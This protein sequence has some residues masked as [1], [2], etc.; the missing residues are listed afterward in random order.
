MIVN[1][2]QSTQ[3]GSG[4]FLLCLPVSGARMQPAC[5]VPPHPHFSPTHQEVI[6]YMHVR[7]PSVKSLAEQSSID[8]HQTRRPLFPLGWEG[9]QKL[10]NH[11][12]EKTL[13]DDKTEGIGMKEVRWLNPWATPSAA[14]PHHAPESCA[15]FRCY[16]PAQWNQ[17]NRRRS[18][19]ESTLPHD[20]R[21]WGCPFQ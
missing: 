18:T 3:L 9:H 12:S 16:S 6:A 19:T 13:W 2:L 4:L 8:T 1:V 7:T 11:H 17:W 21:P 10:S 14:Q 20:A 5:R 15:L